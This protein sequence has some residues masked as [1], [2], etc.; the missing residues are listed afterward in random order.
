M[1][2]LPVQPIIQGDLGKLSVEWVIRSTFIKIESS[3]SGIR[4]R[5]MRQ[6]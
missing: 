5:I 2:L 6:E 4:E 1:I 3:F